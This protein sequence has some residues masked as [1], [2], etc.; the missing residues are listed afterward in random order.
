[1]AAFFPFIENSQ[2]NF[3]F[4]PVL[5]GIA[6]NAVV[7]WNFYALRYYVELYK[8]DGARV[9][10]LPVI[11]SPDTANLSIAAGYFTNKLIF[12]TSQNRFEVL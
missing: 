3:K 12:R 10:N 8:A 2:T 1:M 11:G 4:S 6:Y 9:F 7:K 5:D